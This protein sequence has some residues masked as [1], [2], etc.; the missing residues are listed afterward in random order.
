MEQAAAES[1]LSLTDVKESLLLS[2]LQCSERGLLFSANWC[3]CVC[4]A[5]ITAASLCCVCVCIACI[6]AASLCCVCVH[7]LYYCS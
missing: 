6:T 5:C 4:I 1:T 3:V 2:Y 7:C